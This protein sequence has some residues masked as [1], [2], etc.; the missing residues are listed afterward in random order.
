MGTGRMREVC[1]SLGKK[2]T[3]G[4]RLW[5]GFLHP[6]RFVFTMGSLGAWKRERGAKSIKA[7]A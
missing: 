5:A 7:S 1:L 2:A 4:Q 6:A 3:A